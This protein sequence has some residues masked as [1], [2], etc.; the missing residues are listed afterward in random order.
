[1][2][3]IPSLLTVSFALISVSSSPSEIIQE[4]TDTYSVT[5]LGMRHLTI[6]AFPRKTFS[7][8]NMTVYDCDTTEKLNETSSHILRTI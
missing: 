8:T 3:G 4:A 2:K 5:K 1:M 6:A 7:S